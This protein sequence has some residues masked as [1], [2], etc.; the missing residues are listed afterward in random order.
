MEKRVKILTHLII[1]IF[2]FHL[3]EEL[4]TGFY[5]S[6][7]S[8]QVMSRFFYLTPEITFLLVEIVLF[9][10][11]AA[12]LA[13]FLLEKT[14]S[15]LAFIL[16]IICIYEFVHLFDSIKNHIFSSGL[17]TGILLGVM[18]LILISNLLT[19]KFKK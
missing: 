17:I 2:I 1:V 9:I 4:M 15:I 6:E 10:F 11:L 3:L 5:N 12:V 18:G 16:S 19:I 14:S 13:S 8:I 7:K